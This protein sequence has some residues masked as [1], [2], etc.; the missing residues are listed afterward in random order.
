MPKDKQKQDVVFAY[1][2][3]RISRS[4]AEARLKE[5]QFED[6]EIALYLDDDQTG[7]E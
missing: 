2:E 7:P 3:K 6:W 4:V 1:W 5:L